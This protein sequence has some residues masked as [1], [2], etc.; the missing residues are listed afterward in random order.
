MGDA[1]TSLAEPALALAISKEPA[2]L[3]DGLLTASWTMGDGVAVHL[4]ANLSSLEISRAAQPGQ[5][6]DQ[7]SP[8]WGGEPSD[9]LPPWSVFWRLGG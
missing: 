9:R 3:D 6:Q 7:G 2:E 1:I 5:S 4:L 8:I